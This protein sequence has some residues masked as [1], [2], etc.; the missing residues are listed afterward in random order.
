M[1]EIWP[2]PPK[3]QPQVAAPTVGLPRR[4]AAMISSGLL[5]SCLGMLLLMSP[6]LVG[7]GQRSLGLHVPFD[8][9]YFLGVSALSGLIL[10]IV[11]GCLGYSVKHNPNGFAALIVSSAAVVLLFGLALLRTL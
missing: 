2:P 1:S 7:I 8:M 4:L 11:G 9:D 3:N 10:I 6:V 5:Y